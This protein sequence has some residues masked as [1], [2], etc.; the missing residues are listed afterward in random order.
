[1]LVPVGAEHLKTAYLGGAADMLADAGADVVVADI[2]QADGVG[3]ILGKAGS[4]NLLWQFVAGDEL[5]G[6][7]QILVDELVHAALDLLLFLARGLVVEVEAHLALLPIDMGIVRALAAEDSDHR[8]VQQM[9]RRMCWRKLLFVMLVEYIIG[10]QLENLG[11]KIQI[12][13]KLNKCFATFRQLDTSNKQRLINKKRKDMKKVLCLMMSVLALSSCKLELNGCDN[14]L[15][16]ESDN[17][18]TKAYKL[19]PFEEVHMRCVG[20]VELIQDEKKSGTVELTAPDNYMELYKFESDGKELEID[21]A[22]QHINLHTRNVKIKV[23][24]SDL[25][26]LKNSGASS[27]KMDSLDTDKIE[28][29]NSGVGS[30]TIGGVADDV[31]LE[32]SGVGSINAENLKALNVK[33]NVSGV[34]SI[35][36]YASEQIEGNVSGVGSLKYAGHPKHQDNKK[37]GVGSISEM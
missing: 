17:V 27:I 37:S 35:T 9:L 28:I 33:A 7:G 26:A 21:L 6:D 1:M 5:E 10:H 23:Y 25:I 24:T 36:C 14:N 15:I 3:G 16:D 30:I 11:T 13:S 2:H 18:V 20:A 19:K 29:N 31:T 12:Y 34:G 8:L 4:I 32:N 22:K